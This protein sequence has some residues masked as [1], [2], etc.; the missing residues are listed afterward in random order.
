MSDSI[1]S[2][3]LLPPHIKDYAITSIM[4]NSINSSDPS[5]LIESFDV[6]KVLETLRPPLEALKTLVDKNTVEAQ[7]EKIKQSFA[8]VE[9][10]QASRLENPYQGKTLSTIL[11]ENSSQPIDQ[12]DFLATVK[13]IREACVKYKISDNYSLFD[14]LEKLHLEK[15]R[16]IEIDSKDKQPYARLKEELRL[17]IIATD[18]TKVLG[19]LATGGH[20]EQEDNLV[21]VLKLIE[22][23]L[24]T[25]SSVPV[26]DSSLVKQFELEPTYHKG[27]QVS[28]RRADPRLLPGLGDQ[29]LAQLQQH[30][31]GILLESAQAWR[32]DLNKEKS[33]DNSQSKELSPT[34]RLKSFLLSRL[35]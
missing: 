25:A 9:S 21:K 4:S 6:Q 32:A 31:V 28:G 18:A 26:V 12:N 5:N 29:K 8:P 1:N 11:S 14:Q 24:S 10:S 16:S 7:R 22:Q 3:K 34:D 2:S 19:K 15:L 33:A 27:K 23:E 17:G 20:T 35:F 13:Q 30:K